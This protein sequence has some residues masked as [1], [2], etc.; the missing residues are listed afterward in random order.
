MSCVKQR[1]Q[2]QWKYAFILPNATC[3]T[4][5]NAHFIVLHTYPQRMK[6]IG[7]THNNALRPSLHTSPRRASV[8]TLHPRSHQAARPAHILAPAAPAIPVHRKT[9]MRNKKT[10][11]KNIITF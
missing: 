4:S 7:N 9:A 1:K 8:T 11:N 3:L 5:K 10:D 6:N 2:G